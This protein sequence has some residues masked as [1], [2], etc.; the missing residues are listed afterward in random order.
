MGHAT[1]PAPI[2]KYKKYSVV[3]KQ[4]EPCKGAFILLHGKVALSTGVS[5]SHVLQIAYQGEGAILGLAETLSGI[6]YQ[7]TAVA[8]TNITVR[9]LSLTD[10]VNMTKDDASKGL[11]VMSTLIADLDTLQKKKIKLLAVYQ[12]KPKKQWVC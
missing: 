4:E 12:P 5:V 11:R 3:F 1:S 9:F 7:T 6:A 2:R 8:A 10:V